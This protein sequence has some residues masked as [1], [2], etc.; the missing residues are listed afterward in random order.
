MGK[1]HGGSLPPGETPHY[2]A[3]ISNPVASYAVL[4]VL[5]EMLDLEMDMFDLA[6]EAEQMAEMI[7]KYIRHFTAP[8]WEYNQGEEDE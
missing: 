6:K 8:L 5:T 7:D 4:G 2:A 1:G 3:E